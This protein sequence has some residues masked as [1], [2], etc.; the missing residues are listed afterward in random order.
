[1]LRVRGNRGG[2]QRE[3][4]YRGRYRFV[5]RRPSPRSLAVLEGCGTVSG[6]LYFLTMR[7]R[8][9]LARTATSGWSL[10][11]S[12]RPRGSVEENTAVIGKSSTAA[13]NIKRR[14]L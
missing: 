9:S 7:I 5:H 6:H 4:N 3:A 2:H 13:S 10:R 12:T 8:P 11:N 1:L 14:S